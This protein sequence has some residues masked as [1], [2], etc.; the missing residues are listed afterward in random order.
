MQRLQVQLIGRF[1]SD[2]LH[3]GRWTA[4]AIA[5]ASRKSFFCPL[6]YGLTY[7]AGMSRASWPIECS[8]GAEVMGPDAC[9][10][11]DQTRWYVRQPGSD[12]A[13]CPSLAHDDCTTLIQAGAE[14]FCFYNCSYLYDGFASLVL[15]LATTILKDARLFPRDRLSVGGCAEPNR[16]KASS[17]PKQTGR[18][19]Q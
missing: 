19:F 10:H 18:N 14:G 1:G 12:L 16:K 13:A 9:L 17:A 5:S 4:S 7:F 15:P 11:A 3:G 2:E 8:P 6:R